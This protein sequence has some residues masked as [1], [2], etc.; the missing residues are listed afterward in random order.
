MTKRSEKGIQFK[1]LNTSLAPGI[2][3]K[4]QGSATRLVWKG[5]IKNVRLKI[6]QQNTNL[7]MTQVLGFTALLKDMSDILWFDKQKWQFF[8]FYF[9]LFRATRACHLG[10][11]SRPNQPGPIVGLAL[12][13]C[14]KFLRCIFFLLFL[15]NGC[16]YTLERRKGETRNCKK[17][18]RQPKK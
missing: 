1:P 9:G 18:N 15:N 11:S 2:A 12:H 5:V 7:G 10:D 16:I 4:N 17:E 8:G 13:G 14:R 6:S 3:V